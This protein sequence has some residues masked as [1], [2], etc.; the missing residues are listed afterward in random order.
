MLPLTL[1]LGA[2]DPVGREQ[3]P[4]LRDEPTSR[5][6]SGRTAP[7]GPTWKSDGPSVTRLTEVRRET[8]DDA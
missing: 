5:D 6:L 1:K 7:A 3:H 4:R 8:T 2:L